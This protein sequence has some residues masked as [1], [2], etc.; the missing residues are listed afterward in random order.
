M[1]RL[2]RVRDRQGCGFLAAEVLEHR[3]LLSSAAAAVHRATHHAA[4]GSVGDPADN[5]AVQAAPHAAFHATLPGRVSINGASATPV[6]AKFSIGN[7]NVVEGAKVTAKFSFSFASGGTTT[8]VKGSFVGT[9]SAI[10]PQPGI[11]YIGITPTGGLIT[12]TQKHKGVHTITAKAVSD[13]S[14]IGLQLS[15]AG[16][17]IGMSGRYAFTPDSLFANQP[18]EIGIGTP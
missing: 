17:F 13:G 8:T 4:I 3:A 7:V 14:P 16:T 11:T 10:N 15:P 12:L 5:P 2:R 6:S 9:I 1:P 18:I